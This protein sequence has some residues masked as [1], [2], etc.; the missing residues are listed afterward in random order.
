VALVGYTN[1]GKSTLFNRLTSAEVVA[2]DMLFATLDPT[3][4]KLALPGG[5]EVIVSDT[6]GF[7]SEL[8]TQLV[9]AFRAT[10][11]EVIE[12]D[13]ILHVRDMSHADSEAQ[14]ADVAEVL[15][16]LDIDPAD[17]D[18]IVEVWNKIDLLGE[19]GSEALIN[20]AARLPSAVAV[21]ALTGEGL[22]DLVA[23]IEQR[24]AGLEQE[25]EVILPADAGR[26]VNWIYENG[27]VTQ[28][29]ERRDGSVVLQV[30]VSAGKL[31]EFRQRAARAI[32]A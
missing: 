32:V 13:L 19:G 30:R 6:V 25:L 24:V 17:A 8:P 18:H 29:T 26:T 7:I 23:L 4:R 5:G 27:Q 11:E 15:A 20:A 28:R 14:R 16:S 22:G 1:A 10:L 3:L 31:D 21:S 9:A 2:E 12:A